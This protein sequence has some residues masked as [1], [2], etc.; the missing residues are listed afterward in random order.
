MSNRLAPLMSSKS[1][2]WRTPRALFLG[3]HRQYRFE[4][5]AAAS[6]E[7]AQLPVYFTE[8]D[9]A[10]AQAWGPRRTW[11]NPP[12]GRLMP[13]WVAKAVSEKTLVVMLVPA[14]TDTAWWH[15][16]VLPHAAQIAYV[17]GRLTFEGAKSSAPFPSAIV[18][19]DPTAKRRRAIA[20]DKNG[21]VLK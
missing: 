9:N 12:Y 18:T 8:K 10:L 3:L 15:Q 19:F 5:D 7:N 16:F 20:I 6:S 17:R 4:L 1:K 11:L 13:A 14:R 2:E 21:R